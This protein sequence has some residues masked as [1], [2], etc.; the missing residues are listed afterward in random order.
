MKLGSFGEI[1][2]KGGVR[3]SKSGILENPA[4]PAARKTREESS[5]CRV[6]SEEEQVKEK[7]QRGNMRE[8]VFARHDGD[9]TPKVQRARILGILALV[10]WNRSMK[11][12]KLVKLDVNATINTRQCALLKTRSAELRRSSFVGHPLILEAGLERKW[13]G[14]HAAIQKRLRGVCASVFIYPPCSW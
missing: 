12:K 5:F 9:E 7:T 3:T 2:S 10:C 13:S 14:Y 4:L 8:K 11:R 6:S 1:K